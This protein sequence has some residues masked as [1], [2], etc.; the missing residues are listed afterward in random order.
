[1]PALAAAVLTPVK[2]LAL[3]LGSKQLAFTPVASSVAHPGLP[4]EL[5]HVMASARSDVFV[6]LSLRS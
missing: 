6:H 1:M 3:R 2:P 4:G 5:R